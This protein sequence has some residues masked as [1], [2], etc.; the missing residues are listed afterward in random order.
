MYILIIN[1]HIPWVY[2]LYEEYIISIHNILKKYYIIDI[3]IIFY[4]ISSFTENSISLSNINKYDKI[5][6]GGNIDIF[7][8]TFIKLINDIKKIYFINIEQLSNELYYNSISTI[9]NKINI[10]D[11]SEENNIYVNN[12]IFF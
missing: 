7:N 9:N 12:V 11:Y 3:D 2:R 5:F 6:Y 4:D 1:I 10:I 8:N